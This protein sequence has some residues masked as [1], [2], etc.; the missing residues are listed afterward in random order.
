M[1]NKSKLEGEKE[2]DEIKLLTTTAVPQLIN[3]TGH[4]IREKQPEAPTPWSV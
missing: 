1:G 3:T 4:L 2:R